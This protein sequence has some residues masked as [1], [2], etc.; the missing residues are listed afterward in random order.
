VIGP[1][2]GDGARTQ[3]EHATAGVRRDRG[4]HA[5]LARLRAGGE[6]VPTLF[7]PFHGTPAAACRRRDHDVLRVH[8]HLHPETA[9]DVRGDHADTTLG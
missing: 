2:V 1:G 4:V 6:G 9:P 7:G 3:R 5:L 8:L